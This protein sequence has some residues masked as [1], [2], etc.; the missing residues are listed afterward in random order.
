MG[1]ESHYTSANTGGIKRGD[2]AETG[3][4][5]AK[6]TETVTRAGSGARGGYA[7]GGEGQVT[8]DPSALGAQRGPVALDPDNILEDLTVKDADDPSLG[9]TDTE[10]EPAD[11][12]AADTGPTRSTESEAPSHKR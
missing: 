6:P 7:G 10:D 3:D 11:D 12:W 4:L 1:T 5:E 2:S 8:A 9:L